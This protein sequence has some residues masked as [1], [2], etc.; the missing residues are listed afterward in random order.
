MLILKLWIPET[1]IK[2][3]EIDGNKNFDEM[4]QEYKSKIQ[5]GWKVKEV[6]AYKRSKKIKLICERI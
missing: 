1:N 5:D 2:E 3:I 4:M 6:R